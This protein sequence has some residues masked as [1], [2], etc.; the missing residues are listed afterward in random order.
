MSR[1]WIVRPLAESDLDQAVSWYEGQQPGL[2]L[3]FLVAADELF[4]RL[5]VS[6][7]QFPLVSTD[8]RRALVHTF[9]YAVYFR[10]TDEEI[11]VLAV[12]HLRRDPR[13]W[14]TRS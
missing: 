8:V 1:R 11:V 2:G 10:A 5:R 12:L 4:E 13:S 3:R 14:R 7:Q 6:P 9:P